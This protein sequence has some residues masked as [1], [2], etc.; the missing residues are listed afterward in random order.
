MMLHIIDPYM[1]SDVVAN[2]KSMFAIML[3]TYK[4]S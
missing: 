2:G 3:A 1:E 4:S